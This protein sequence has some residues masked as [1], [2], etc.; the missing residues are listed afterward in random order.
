M[1]LCLISTALALTIPVKAT[2]S[3]DVAPGERPVAGAAT[4]ATVALTNPASGATFVVSADEL[5]AN[6]QQAKGRGGVRFDG[7]PAGSVRTWA[8]YFLDA[9][10]AVLGDP[11]IATVA[12]DAKG[13]VSIAAREEGRR[14]ADFY[15]GKGFE[16]SQ[17]PVILRVN[18]QDSGVEASL[19]GIVELTNDGSDSDLVTDADMEVLDADTFAAFQALDLDA[20]IALDTYKLQLEGTIEV[21]D[22]KAVGGVVESGADLR[23][24]VSFYSGDEIC[25][26]GGGCTPV[27]SSVSSFL[28]PIGT[29]RKS[30][31][32][33]RVT[34]DESDLTYDS[35]DAGFRFSFGGDV[36]DLELAASLD[37]WDG[38]KLA[39]SS[40]VILLDPGIYETMVCECGLDG[41]S[42]ECAPCDDDD[43]VLVDIFQDGDCDDCGDYDFVDP[44][45]PPSWVFLADELV[46]VAVY[47]SGGGFVSGHTCTLAPTAKTRQGGGR[48]VLIGECTRDDAGTEVRRLRARIDDK[49]VIDLRL[50]LAGEA[51]AGR[52]AGTCDA[53]GNCTA[54]TTVL[55]GYVEVTIDDTI[56]SKGRMYVTETGYSLPFAFADDVEGLD[57]EL[58]TMLTDPSHP[59]LTWDVK[60]DVLYG[61]EGGK[62][63]YAIDLDPLS[64]EPTGLYRPPYVPVKLRSPEGKTVVLSPR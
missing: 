13:T 64:V 23:W 54:D 12:F 43:D 30:G 6:K 52:R 63:V 2:L 9:T 53:R 24:D 22:L 45:D 1:Y 10:G 11:E 49:G 37:A 55:G 14:T 50:E 58:T 21:K 29:L 60:E 56:V 19:V 57:L 36:S 46:E 47:D 61:T 34:L 42:G 32:P 35:W 26:R 41:D 20:V 4:T 27:A 8:I 44:T 39:D 40:E 17:V 28:A 25:S 18:V 5:T 62:E 33:P 51:L 59:K 3:E 38:A 15:T 31:L 48:S 16:S 7:D